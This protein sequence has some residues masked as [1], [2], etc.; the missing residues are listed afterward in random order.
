M[1]I[2]AP[3]RVAGVPEPG[4]LVYVR[5]RHWVVIGVSAGAL[6]PDVLARREE[7]PQ[8]LVTLSSVE[9]DGLGQ[10]LTVVWE[11]EPAAR[12]LATGTLPRPVADRFDPP[13]RLNA[14]LDAVRWGAVTSA[15][16]RAL[17]A[18]FRS[19][20]TIEDYQLDPVVRALGMPRVN[21]L[22]ADDVGL[23]KTIEAGLV[24]QELLLRH[25]ARTVLIVCPA[26][27]CVKWRD[28]MQDKFGLEF[29]IVDADAVRRLRRERGVGA[30]IFTHF[31]RLIVSMDWLKRPR[32][33][34]L[35]AD[36]LPP[37]ATTY[38]RRFDLLIV[39]EVHQAAPS[40]RGRY[41]TDSQR[42]TLL[43]TL[44]PHF[45]HRLFLSATPHNG[46]SESWQATLEMLDPQRFARGVTPNPESLQR[47]LVRR[48]KSDLRKD[49]A[50]AYRADGTPRFPQRVL[51][52][53]EVDY[54]QSEHDVHDDL[55]R[56]A[57]LCRARAKNRSA[58]VAADFVTLLLK[59]RL[60]SSPAAFAATLAVHLDT[61]A[62][63]AR[64]DQAEDERA[65]GRLTAA[66]ERL[67]E[68]V[69]DDE[70]LATSTAD[71]L[72]TA[73]RAT[74]AVT[75]EQRQLL[76]RMLAW[77]QQEKDRPDAKAQRL[78]DWLKE[79]VAPG[80]PD[81]AGHRGF[82]D[83]R[84]IIFTEYRDSQD[85]LE[86]L[87]TAE[88][89]G[90]DR[91]A[92]L[93]GGMDTET[94]ERVKAEF[95]TPPSLRP[96]RI[97]LATDAASEGIDLQRY[98]HRLVHLEIPFSPTRLEQRNG[99]VDRHLQP[100]PTVD[101]YHFVP[102]GYENAP[103]G[104]LDGDLQF[105][106][107]IAHKVDQ[108]RDDLGSAGPVL[109]T[110]VE[111]AML[112]RRRH[113]DDKA[114]RSERTRRAQAALRRIERNLREEVAALRDALSTSVTE[115]GLTSTAVQRVVEVGL[116]LARQ[117]PL[118]PMTLPREPGDTRPA[119]PAFVV[120]PLT[121]SW[122]R[123][124]AD[125]YDPIR[126]TQLPITFDPE[127]AGAGG[128]VV[129]AHLGHRL[130]AQSL[131]LLR[132]EIW[133]SGADRRL[134]RVTARV[135]AD[136]SQPEP[137]VLA[138]ARL[139]ITGGDGHRLHEE[140]VVA[141]GRIGNTGFARYNV[142]QVKAA[143]AAPGEEL[144]PTHLLEQLAAAWPRLEQPLF[145][146]LQARADDRVTSLERT[147]AER[148]DADAATIGAVLEE[149]RATIT[150]QLDEL[151]QDQQLT[152]FEVDERA[153]FTRDVDALRRR[154]D[155]IPAEIES[156]Q[157]AV[158]HRYADPQPLL[159]PAAVTFLIPRRFLA[160]SL[161]LGGAR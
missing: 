55:A 54:P 27:L 38:P 96:V 11:L 28:E 22:V 79:T 87:L 101:I 33:M 73:A 84:V 16:S 121:R 126:D 104:S 116:Q 18:P 41:A 17:Q 146:S 59:K 51:H 139:V 117:A 103:T 74:G 56:Y 158:R 72:Q 5:D 105:L 150:R 125:L 132:A 15:D 20:I 129:L 133:A 3:P 68:E 75:D 2:V 44:A 30:N 61:L 19:G 99:R 66:F 47:V 31:P 113:I 90:G 29:R 115:L 93:Y 77:A 154:I 86:R 160:G 24:V 4:Q 128:D 1:T 65:M 67:D 161:P 98:C 12:A 135:V 6:P 26:S 21:L 100:S 9:D 40:G 148:A 60:F 141:G 32:G 50:T 69:A 35:L 111:E 102:K 14:F 123:I 7:S 80:D 112:G 118:Q 76:E 127:V 52:A 134:G 70:E 64:P 62:G 57:E 159:F 82:T 8:H 110:Q 95:Q 43:R 142:G 143:L 42:T 92:L 108:I 53:L 140:V 37:D 78:L 71:A 88:G 137:A 39:D 23:G 36:V 130:V 49:P 119:G 10:D 144:P 136:D 91:L 122:A 131:R 124:N 81:R 120:P 13:V 149:L 89:M 106:S 46:Y 145:R 152:L 153:Q 45:E 147:L 34:A 155:A 85:W 58:A 156:E 83:E 97:L 157:A 107:L 48:L 109:A 63:R 151:D 94:R 25:R 138:H 114:L